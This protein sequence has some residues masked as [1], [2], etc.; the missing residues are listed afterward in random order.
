S[1]VESYKSNYWKHHYV[2]W[3]RWHCC[4]L[5]KII[6]PTTLKEV[7]ENQPIENNKTVTLQNSIFVL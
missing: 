1:S 5:L 7:V 2:N 6:Q 3:A 4:K